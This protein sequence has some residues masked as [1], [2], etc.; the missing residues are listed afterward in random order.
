[1]RSTLALACAIAAVSAVAAHA[2]EL[3]RSI[4]LY[5]TSGPAL[6]MVD[7]KID[8]TVRGPIVEAVVTQRFQNR[9]DHATEATYVFPLPVDAAVSAMSIKYGNRVIHASIE[10]REEAQRRYE[11][12]VRAGTHGALLDQERPDVFT[13]TVAAIPARGAV[14]ITLRF[15]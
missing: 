11:A 5:P 3:P 12:A 2:G 13:Q 4:G 8:V 6:A 1:M 10:K 15:D 7:S 9:T 14:E